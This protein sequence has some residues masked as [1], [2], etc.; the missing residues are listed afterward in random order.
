MLRAIVPK[1]NAQ[2]FL[3]KPTTPYRSRHPL[4]FVGE[5]TE[6]QGLFPEQLT[7]MQEHLERLKQLG[8]ED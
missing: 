3:G 1:L 4:R 8:I 5:V 2:K 7:A 6:W